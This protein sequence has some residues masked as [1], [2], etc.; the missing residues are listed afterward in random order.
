M[1]L[2]TL[3]RNSAARRALRLKSCFTRTVGLVTWLISVILYK[4]AV[5]SSSFSY[6]G[7]GKCERVKVETALHVAGALS[8]EFRIM[9]HILN[10]LSERGT[11]CRGTFVE[12]GANDGLNSHSKF[13]ENHLGWRGYCI[14]AAPNNFKS[15]KLN[16]PNC[17][18]INAVIWHRPEHVLFRA[19]T[20]K[21]YG[22]SGIVSSRTSEEWNNLLSLHGASSQCR[23]YTIAAKPAVEIID[24]P[25][26]DLFFLDVEGAEL[27]VLHTWQWDALHVKM[28][29]IESNKLNRTILVEYMVNHGYECAHFDSINTF[30]KADY[31]S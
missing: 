12:L 3:P 22:H 23:D 7:L 27:E 15:L 2:N 6:P 11:S 9:R 13:L 10:V 25:V 5:R 14:E 21:L 16:R 17:K 28:W 30:C 4:I 18:N 29:V 24:T 19:C 20:G 1:L 26:I 31:N 8:G